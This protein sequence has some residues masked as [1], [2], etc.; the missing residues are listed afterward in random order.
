[1]LLQGPHMSVAFEIW[2][3]SPPSYWV[4]FSGRSLRLLFVKSSDLSSVL[5]PKS[6]ES[7]CLSLC[8]WGLPPPGFQNNSSSPVFLTHL[9]LFLWEFLSFFPAPFGFNG[10]F[11]TDNSLMSISGS[12]RSCFQHFPCVAHF[13]LSLASQHTRS[14]GQYHLLSSSSPEFYPWL[15]ILSSTP[16][17]KAGK[18]GTFY[19]HSISWL[20]PP[21]HSHRF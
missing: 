8:S 3:L 6:A 9:F 10:N 19:G 21:F 17:S 1:M 11:C 15:S 5:T 13:L 16:D 20:P 12:S 18:S 7:G 4:L 2:L 14:S